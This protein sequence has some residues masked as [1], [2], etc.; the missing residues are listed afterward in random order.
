MAAAAIVTGATAE[1]AAVSVAQAAGLQCRLSS[2]HYS[3]RTPLNSPPNLT[4]HPAP[5]ASTL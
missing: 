3:P 4:G 5:P 2:R 1:A